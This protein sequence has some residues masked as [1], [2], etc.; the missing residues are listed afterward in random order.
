M[1]CEEKNRVTRLGDEG[2]VSELFFPASKYPDLTFVYSC[3]F[4]EPKHVQDSAASAIV[5][6]K[7]SKA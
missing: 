6:S 5:T 2:K 7:A 3:S 1:R 4:L